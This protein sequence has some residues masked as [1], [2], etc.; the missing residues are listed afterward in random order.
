MKKM[1][2]H[3]RC[4]LSVCTISKPILKEDTKLQNLQFSHYTSIHTKYLKE[5][6]VSF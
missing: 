5:N 3:Q 4:F 2:V 1:Q 6:P